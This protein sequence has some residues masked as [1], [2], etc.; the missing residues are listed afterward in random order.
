MAPGQEADLA[1]PPMS[2]LFASDFT[3]PQ[4][5]SP[6]PSSS[7]STPA[8]DPSRLTLS[9]EKGVTAAVAHHVSPTL[10]GSTPSPASL[11]SS[12]SSPAERPSLRVTNVSRPARASASARASIVRI[13]LEV[14]PH[15]AKPIRSFKITLGEQDCQTEVV[16]ESGRGTPVETIQLAALIPDSQS[17]VTAAGHARRHTLIVSALD[18]H[19]QVMAFA[20]ANG[21]NF[22]HSQFLLLSFLVRCFVCM[23]V[24]VLK[25]ALTLLG[26]RREGYGITGKECAPAASSRTTSTALKYPRKQP[27]L[28]HQREPNCKSSQASGFTLG[29]DQS[30]TSP[31]AHCIAGRLR[32][33]IEREEEDAPSKSVASL[34]SVSPRQPRRSRIV[35][36][37]FAKSDGQPLALAFD[38]QHASRGTDL[39]THE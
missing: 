3:T 21:F 37:D 14:R 4:F 19:E 6:S 33:A 13:L 20:L 2:P 23:C 22:L 7:A 12:S 36:I 27:N 8:I 39:A 34:F 16:A 15:P 31:S 32:R 30:S 35:E 9:D 1:I 10:D 29:L 25:I 38:S 28:Q 24:C 26:I 11:P 18:Q 5:L 17:K